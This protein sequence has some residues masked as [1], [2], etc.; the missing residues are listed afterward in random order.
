VDLIAHFQGA[1]TVVS[2]QA[3]LP[4]FAEGESGKNMFVLMEGT[5]A[6][7]VGGEVVEVAG[8]GSL[9]GEMALINSS[10]RSAT[11]IARSNCRVI[12]INSPQFDLLVRE[13]PEFARHVMEVMADRLRHMN[14]KFKDVALSKRPD[15]AG[16]PPQPARPASPKGNTTL[17]A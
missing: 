7:C 9:L 6:I 15:Q 3:G 17:R 4:I 1:R 5:V 16:S 10:F 2:I 13:S 14:Q 8:P 11:A 12:S